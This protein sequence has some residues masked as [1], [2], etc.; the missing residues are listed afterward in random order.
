MDRLQVPLADCEQDFVRWAERQVSLLRAK[1]FEQ[2]DIDH[3]VEG[4]EGMIGRDRRE[5]GS[6]LK[7]V[8]IHL[9]KCEFQPA[10]KS[11]SWLNTLA[12][13]R[14]EIGELL[15][16]SPSL[17]QGIPAL[18]RRRYR[19]A[20]LAAA[21]EA[22]LPPRTFPSELPYSEDQLLDQGFVP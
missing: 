1:Q 13:Q 14:D 9:L 4:L 5:L 17:A 12:H 21:R 16:D 11:T 22:H 6:R 7:V 10:L 19:Q 15:Q 2:L 18:A 20:V 8:M 3:L